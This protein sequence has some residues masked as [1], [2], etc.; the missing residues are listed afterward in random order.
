M[1]KSS[2]VS[3]I[4]LLLSGAASTAHAAGLNLI[5]NGDFSQGCGVDYSSAYSCVNP[6]DPMAIWPDG[7]S[8]VVTTA[9]HPLWVPATGPGVGLNPFLEVN[10]RTDHASTVWFQSVP[11]TAGQ[12]YYFEGYVANLCCNSS[13]LQDVPPALEIW[14]NGVKVRDLPTDGAGT[15]LMFGFNWI[16][17]TAT[18]FLEIRD[19]VTAYGGNDFGVGLL[20]ATQNVP[21]PEPVS[22]VLFGT[23]LT[24]L[25][26]RRYKNGRV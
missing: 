2:I 4:T 20:S 14:R 13:A 8:A 15:W 9:S 24:G 19:T 10:G 1:K 26:I 7:T 3:L 21:A 12:G 16:A 11:T 25:F 22:L 17:D 23:G 6:N 5:Q 18:E